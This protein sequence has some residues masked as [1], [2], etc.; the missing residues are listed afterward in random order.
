MPLLSERGYRETLLSL[1]P[2]D[3]DAPDD[4]TFY[5]TMQAS[6]GF[7]RDEERSNSSLFN[8]QAYFDRKNT[9]RQLIKDGMDLNAYTNRNG[10]FNY[11]KLAED[12]GLVKSNKELFEERNKMLAERRERNQ[13]VM[14]RGNGF[15]QFLGMAGS[16][17]SDPINIASLPFGGVG[18]GAKGLSVLSRAMVGAR[19]MAGVSLASEMAIQPLVYSHK[20]D[21]DSPYT[22]EDSLRV[23]GITAIT[24]GVL[25]GGVQGVAGYLAKSAEKAAKY[26]SVR[27]G[28]YT[29]PPMKWQPSIIEGKAA[30]IPTAKNIEIVR[31][32]L[33][34]EQTS[35]LTATASERLTVPERKKLKGELRS[36]ERRLELDLNKISKRLAKETKAAKKTK[37]KKALKAKANAERKA[38]RDKYNPL[39]KRTQQQINKDAEALA[40]QSQLERIKQG[41]VPKLEEKV[42]KELDDW[43]QQNSTPETQSV[44]AIEKI[45]ENLRLQKGFRAEEVALEAFEGFA[46]GTVKSIDKARQIAIQLLRDKLKTLDADGSSAKEVDS[47]INKLE[48][49]DDAEAVFNDLFK[50]NIEKDLRILENNEAVREAIETYTVKPEEYNP[51]AKPP[52]P[53]ADTTNLQDAALTEAG[54]TK[55]Y[56][57]E[58]AIYNTLENKRLFDLDEDGNVVFTSA[59]DVIKAIDDDLEGLESIMRCSRV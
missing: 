19:N 24:A 31:T 55:A 57:E 42:Q 12:T 21:I 41:Q 8:N 53:K 16:Y 22:V 28:I 32:K 13:D 7:V 47:L 9:V 48:A 2:I 27:E 17:M 44:Y 45:A 6:Y 25:G 34:N 29:K 30:S 36:L 20:N 49:T 56:N 46:N 15:A 52:A 11:D 43:I 10:A 58:M 59:D 4:P 18:A 26:L 37:D 50:A 3:Y 35:K 54:F 40:A 1:R 14:E 51:K 23:I 38:L 39:I 33:F 5:E